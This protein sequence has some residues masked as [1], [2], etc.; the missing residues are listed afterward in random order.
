MDRPDDAVSLA[1]PAAA[2]T[3]VNRGALVAVRGG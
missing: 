2:A 3:K 1:G